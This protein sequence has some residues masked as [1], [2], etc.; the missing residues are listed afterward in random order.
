MR[1][2]RGR[3]KARKT[4]IERVG[5][6]AGRAGCCYEARSR[7]CWMRPIWH[8]RCLCTSCFEY[9]SR[10]RRRGACEGNFYDSTYR[11]IDTC[12]SIASLGANWGRP[13]DPGRHKAASGKGG[14][15]L[16][17]RGAPL[18]LGARRGAAGGCAVVKRAPATRRTP[19]STWRQKL[20]TMVV[21]FPPPCAACPPTSCN[22]WTPSA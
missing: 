8:N 9:A 21:S 10:R 14:R 5:T 7:S 20:L 12:N 1:L 2:E 15:R 22:V 13:N 4:R 17:E 6:P 19:R 16:G 18:G 11:Y 3:R